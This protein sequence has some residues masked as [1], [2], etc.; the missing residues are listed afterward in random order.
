MI[1]SAGLSRLLRLGNWAICCNT[2]LGL[3]AYEMED[4]NPSTCFIDCESLKICIVN[5]TISI[6]QFFLNS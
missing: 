6:I 2:S 5:I 3:L 4:M 1:R